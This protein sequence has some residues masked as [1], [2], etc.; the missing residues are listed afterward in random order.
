M[1]NLP[2]PLV[3]RLRRLA[4]KTAPW[5]RIIALRRA[6]PMGAGARSGASPTGIAGRFSAWWC[7]LLAWP[8]LVVLVQ[9]GTSVAPR[10]WPA[11]P[12]VMAG[13]GGQC[14]W[15]RWRWPVVPFSLALQ[16]AIAVPWWPAPVPWA[17]PR[18]PP[19]PVGAGLAARS[20]PAVRAWRCDRDSLPPV[21]PFCSTKRHPS[22]PGPARSDRRRS[23]RRSGSGKCEPEGR[24]ELSPNVLPIRKLARQAWRQTHFATP[25]RTALL[26]GGFGPA[27]FYRCWRWEDS[28]TF[29][30][31]R[32]AGANRRLPMGLSGRH[33][34]LVRGSGRTHRREAA[35]GVVGLRS[36]TPRGPPFWRCRRRW[37]LRPGG[38]DDQPRPETRAHP[39]ALPSHGDGRAISAAI[40][41]KS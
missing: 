25:W 23:W 17:W 8:R 16:L 5:L 33:S 30:G 7:C 32:R 1:L 38:V 22:N 26:E 34:W 20:G 15:L 10:C 37:V 9:W 31:A 14:L 4:P 11:A 18:P 27:S 19:S 35:D 12:R 24:P 28:R 6:G 39:R 36:E 3:L 29:A 40:P 13:M 2:G 21:S 41:R